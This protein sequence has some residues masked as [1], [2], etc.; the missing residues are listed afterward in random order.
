MSCTFRDYHG[1]RTGALDPVRAA[2]GVAGSFLAF[3]TVAA[4]AA[5]SM[6]HVAVGVVALPERARHH[7]EDRDAAEV[8]SRLVGRRCCSA[9]RG[10]VGGHCAVT[11]LVASTTLHDYR[12]T[13][14]RRQWE[15]GRLP[16]IGSIS[17]GAACLFRET[18]AAAQLA[19]GSWW[20]LRAL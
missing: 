11:A 12:N 5:G 20:A 18:V 3:S 10:E 9:V 4:E 6:V 19:E 16:V 7:V 15:A 14:C 8:R 17:S 13:I 1:P 2:N